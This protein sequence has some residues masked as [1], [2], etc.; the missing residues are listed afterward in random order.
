MPAGFG[1]GPNTQTTNNNSIKEEEEGYDDEDDGG[2]GKNVNESIDE[3]VETQNR[4]TSDEPLSNKPSDSSREAKNTLPRSSEEFPHNKTP[5]EILALS[6][7]SIR[8]P[9][10]ERAKEKKSA[11]KGLSSD[12]K[13]L[14]SKPSPRKVTLPE[15]TA[16]SPRN[17]KGFPTRNPI[18]RIHSSEIRTP[19]YFVPPGI[20]PYSTVQQRIAFLRLKRLE[21]LRF[22]TRVS[23][24]ISHLST[25]YAL[26]IGISLDVYNH[27]YIETLT[28]VPPGPL[29][30]IM[31]FGAIGPQ[32]FL[33]PPSLVLQSGYD[34]SPENSVVGHPAQGEN[35]QTNSVDDVYR[36][37]AFSEENNDENEPPVA[38][39]PSYQMVTSP[40]SPSGDSRNRGRLSRGR[41][42]SL[43]ENVSGFRTFFDHFNRHDSFSG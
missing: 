2:G 37:S 7:A 34:S 41:R 8:V 17:P 5:R 36:D 14:T 30:Q 3:G 20:D 38:S 4:K 13:A 28:R 6:E 15:D 18:D 39:S 40:A 16:P 29:D 42:D 11:R 35:P 25:L 24:L 23:T 27:N 43:V 1:E 31:P 26:L 33:R 19:E 9:K 12:P 21:N 22:Q 10:K 32:Y